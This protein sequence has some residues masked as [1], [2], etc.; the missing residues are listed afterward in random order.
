MKYCFNSF[1]KQSQNQ[2]SEDVCASCGSNLLLRDRYS[3][4]AVIGRGGFGK[5]YLATDE[6]E[7]SS[8]CVI[9]QFLPP[10]NSSTA[11][12]LFAEEAQQ[13][14]T[15]GSHSQI[16]SFIDYLEQEN[17]YFIVQEYIDG[18]N[19]EEELAANG[20]FSENQIQELLLNILPVIEFVHSHNVIHRDIKPEN[21]IRRHSD[22]EDGMP[23]DHA[24]QTLRDHRSLHLVDFGAAKIITQTALVKTGTTIGS[25]GYAAPEQ[26][27]GKAVTQSDLYSL[28]V[29]C[30][31]LLTSMHPFDLIDSGEGNWVWRDYLKQPVSQKL[32]QILDKLLER[33]IKQRYHSAKE[34]LND[35]QHFWQ[36]SQT[37][38]ASKFQ[39]LEF[40][41]DPLEELEKEGAFVA[42]NGKE[43]SFI[44]NYGALG[45]LKKNIVVPDKLIFHQESFAGETST[46]I[47][48]VSKNQKELTFPFGKLTSQAHQQFTSDY[49]SCSWQKL[50]TSILSLLM[51][52][53]DEK[54]IVESE[55]LVEVLN[56]NEPL[57]LP[58]KLGRFLVMVGLIYVGSSFVCHVITGHTL[59][60]M[61]KVVIEIG[62]NSSSE[63][64]QVIQKYL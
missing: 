2:D 51:P 50:E 1:C 21:V 52:L 34:V 60:E 46:F 37:N 26:T 22:A 56:R 33:G 62:K 47:E 8:L 10:S 41:C 28:G 39:E 42:E 54:Q 3:A 4:I 25:A 12:R 44:P 36:I 48:A 49:P 5:T 20:S 63:I 29:T 58:Q 23:K 30:I 11:L 19:L 7:P 9:K 15:L 24:T 53:L 16:P 13:L 27:F 45:L 43:Y 64:P 35:L 55:K 17:E 40:I 59:P 31:H 57:T 61:A 18:S 6:L 32:G 14:R 38:E